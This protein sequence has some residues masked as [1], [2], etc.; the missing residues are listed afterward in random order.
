VVRRVV[1]FAVCA[2][3][4]YG[5][6][7]AVTEVLGAWPRVRRI[8]PGWFAGM[9]L[10]Q[11][12]SL[13]CLWKLQ[14]LCI[15]AAMRPVAESSLVSGALGRVLPGG[16]ATA[17]ATQYAMLTS[18][19]VP[20]AAIGAGL[21]AGTLLQL[22][23][24]CALALLALP[25]V[26]LGLRVPT[27]LLATAAVAAVLFCGMVAL[28]ALALRGDRALAAMARAAGRLLTRVRP[29]RPVD[30]DDLATGLLSQRD[31][32]V[33]LLGHTW[34]L[35]LVVAVGRWVLDFLTLIAAL[36]AIGAD[37][38]GSL[39]LL[40]Y[41]G[42]QLLAQ[43]PLTPGGLGVVEAGLTGSLAL[44]GITAGQAAVATLAYRLVS[45]W[46]LLPAGLVAWLLFR[47]E[48]GGTAASAP[49]S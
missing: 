45:Y 10:A 17:A 29:R 4:L 39:T 21:A 18:A 49:A 5:V 35:A 12:G 34:R 16:T 42:A 32:V 37:P 25:A 47:R 31:A 36:A 15:G 14:A 38:H 19:G 41:A 43:L 28:T 9:V 24:L 26:L 6:A 8:E 3:V 20:G 30:P 27:S 46:L 23:A 44:A 1:A 13:W 40:A 2:L 11:L 33:E 48:A 22:A 7:P